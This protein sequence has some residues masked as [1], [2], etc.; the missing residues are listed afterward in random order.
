MNLGNLINRKLIESRFENKKELY[1]AMKDI[2]GDNCCAYNTFTEALSKNKSLSDVELLTLSILLDIDLNK[3]ALHY[4]KSQ[5]NALS[6]MSV[7]EYLKEN[8]ESILLY[9]SYLSGEEY[10]SPNLDNTILDITDKKIYFL[11]ITKKYN[12][13]LLYEFDIK[14]GNSG[15]LIRTNQIAKFDYF[16]NILE[17]SELDIHSFMEL[18]FHKKI[19]FLKEEGKVYYDLFPELKRE[20]EDVYLDGFEDEFK[21]NFVNDYIKEHEGYITRTR[22]YR[23]YDTEGDRYCV[24][25]I[26]EGLENIAELKN[27]Y[28]NRLLEMKTEIFRLFREKALEVLPVYN[29]EADDN[30]E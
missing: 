14:K 24:A 13:V 9:A 25:H 1:E 17:E 20:I 6:S 22:D 18:D 16:K 27:L 26:E 28:L 8:K 21:N 4:I 30:I 7:E 5:K 11:T 3:L 12:S 29:E 15:Y 2:I 23:L 19:E 10:E